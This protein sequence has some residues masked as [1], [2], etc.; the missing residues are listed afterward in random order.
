MI[1]LNIRCKYII[2]LN[3]E[4]EYKLKVVFD[5][6]SKGPCKVGNWQYLKFFANTERMNCLHLDIWIPVFLTVLA[7]AVA[8]SV[9]R[10]YLL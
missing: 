7:V 2:S 3:I 8:A 9:K 4:N 10:N 6:V 5:I 1:V